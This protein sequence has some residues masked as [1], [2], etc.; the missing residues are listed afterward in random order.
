MNNKMNIF[1]LFLVYL[2]LVLVSI[3]TAYPLLWMLSTSLQPSGTDVSA[4]GNLIPTSPCW[5]NYR[6]V[7]FETNF[8]RAFLNSTFVTVS[9]TFGVLTTSS[10][11]AYA[12]ARMQFFGRDH[13]FLGYLATL[14]VPGAVTMIPNFLILKQF[15]WL[16]TYW[17]LLIPSMFSA[18]GTFMLRQ[19][20]LSL[21][22][23]LEE[24]ATID[25]CGSLGIYRHV[26]IPLSR[27]ALLTLGILTFMGNWKALQWPLIVTHSADLYTLPLAL[28]KFN[29]L[30]VV[31]WSLLMAG[32]VIM[33]APL[34]ILFLFCQKYFTK[35]IM[36]GAVKG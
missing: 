35:G 19:F 26:V 10:L 20:F 28:T 21:P 30:N 33:T 6:V 23:D 2:G 12:F 32:S 25:G 18:Y 22:R 27:N 11:A 15:G 36:L 3:T 8:M 16:D 1:N 5:D 7:F 34:L 17:A 9:V 13:I 29:E 31:Q 4:F 24:A 14:M